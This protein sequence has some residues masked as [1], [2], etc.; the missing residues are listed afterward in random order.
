MSRVFLAYAA[1]DGALAISIAA[2]IRGIDGIVI[3]G[4]EPPVP[5]VPVSMRADRAGFLVERIA[6]LIG[7]AAD[8]RS[9]RSHL[10]RARLAAL[11]ILRGRR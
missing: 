5:P 8:L 11:R 4:D 10:E 7:V 3:A 2:L 9:V 6:E 1:T